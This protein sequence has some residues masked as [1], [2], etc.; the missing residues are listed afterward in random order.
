MT[1]CVDT[2]VEPMEPARPDPVLNRVLPQSQC[3]QLTVG[4]H[5]ML[6]AGELRHRVVASGRPPSLPPK[7]S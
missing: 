3:P 4:H 2:Q 7:P 6:P 1:D 5:P